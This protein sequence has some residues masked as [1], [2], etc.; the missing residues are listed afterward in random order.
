MPS[1]ISVGLPAE[2]LWTEVGPGPANIGVLV[3]PDEY[4]YYEGPDGVASVAVAADIPFESQLLRRVLCTAAG[5]ESWNWR[6]DPRLGLVVETERRF[7]DG[8]A[9]VN[10]KE[11][12]IGV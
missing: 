2:H 4:L 10:R 3:G 7:R 6:D 5:Q 12:A 1:S 9:W 11:L 8:S